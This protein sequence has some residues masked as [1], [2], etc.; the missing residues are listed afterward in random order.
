[1]GPVWPP[2][3]ILELADEEQKEVKIKERANLQTPT[4]EGCKM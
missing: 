4:S 2:D 1:M 3:M